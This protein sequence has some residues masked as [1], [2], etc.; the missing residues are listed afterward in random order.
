MRN[1]LQDLMKIVLTVG[2]LASFLANLAGLMG[3][4]IESNN[5]DKK[6]KS[7]CYKMGTIATYY[8]PGYRIGCFVFLPFE[9]RH[10]AWK[11]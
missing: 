11:F 3:S 9:D 2:F 10:Y 4:S 7:G 8:N 1:C 6:F 5:M